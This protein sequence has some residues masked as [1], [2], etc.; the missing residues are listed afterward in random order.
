MEAIQ[1]EEQEEKQVEDLTTTTTQ[2]SIKQISRKFTFAICLLLILAMCIFWLISSFNTQNL[3]R[4][5]ADGL[6]QSLARQTAAQLTELMLANDL[7]SMNVVLGNLARDSSI[8]EVS[9]VNVDN[10]IMASASGSEMQV[11]TLKP[12][13]FSL[14]TLQVEYSAP[15]TLADSIA[16]FVRLRLDLSYIEAGTLNNLILIIGATALLL[17][18]AAAVTTTY[19]QYLV[20]FPANLLSFSLSNIRKGEIETCPEPTTNNE[21][22]AVIRQYNATAEFLT[23]LSLIH[24]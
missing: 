17:I 23:Q 12:L 1:N 10:E 7:I 15:I 5:Q 2:S 9:V 16:G 19:F 6:G 13:P 24:I 20:S 4:Q 11:E 3:L 18:V 8:A 22:S 14:S 21:I